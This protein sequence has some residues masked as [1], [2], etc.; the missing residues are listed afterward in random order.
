MALISNFNSLKR[1]NK[2]K[3]GFVGVV[4]L[5]IMRLFNKSTPN[6]K[7]YNWTIQNQICQSVWSTHKRTKEVNNCPQLIESFE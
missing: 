2:E 5:L 3:I 7:T 1:I 6:V 4:T